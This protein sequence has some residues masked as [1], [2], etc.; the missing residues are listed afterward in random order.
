MGDWMYSLPVTW[1]AVVI[2]LLTFA[3]TVGVYALVMGFARGERARVFKAMSPGMLPPL[4]IIFGLFV[5]FLAAEVWRDHD[6]AQT[7]VTR[8]ASALR[9]SVLMAGSFPGEPEARMRSLVR[10]QI[11]QAVNEEWPAMSRHSA[12]LAMIP[13]P[14]GGSAS[15]GAVARAGQR[16]AEDRTARDRDRAGDCARC[17]PA[18]DH[19]Q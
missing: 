8:E 16:R 4:G 6:E 1:M 15:V 7:A 9:A 17:A 2:F 13:H 18:A 3:V 10:R 14:L 12:T 5:A 11:E 19:H